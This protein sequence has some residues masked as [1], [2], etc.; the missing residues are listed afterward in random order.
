MRAVLGTGTRAILAK[1][2]A[3]SNL[4]APESAFSEALKSIP[5]VL[6]HRQLP[7]VEFLEYFHSLSEI[8]D[9]IAVGT[10]RPSKRQ[11]ADASSAATRMIGPSSPPPSS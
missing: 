11:P 7:A 5:P 6:K 8:V 1:Y 9:V 3:S 10:T 4:V 2:G